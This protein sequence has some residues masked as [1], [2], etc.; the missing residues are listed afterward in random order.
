MTVIYVEHMER[1]ARAEVQRYVLTRLNALTDNAGA[2][3]QCDYTGD[4]TLEFTAKGVSAVFSFCP[5]LRELEWH[6]R[7]VHDYYGG[8]EWARPGC[9]LARPLDGTLEA[10][11][12][13][14]TAWLN[15][16][17]MTL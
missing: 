11:A 16:D 2:V 8:E 5:V 13:R 14:V 10:A 3:E 9:L 17:E 7:T 15:N 6:Y 4:W 1:M 12:C